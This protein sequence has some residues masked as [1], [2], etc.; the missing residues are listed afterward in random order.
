MTGVQS[1]KII[2]YIPAVI[3]ILMIVVC[4]CLLQTTDVEELLEFT[5]AEPLMALGVLWLMYALKSLS[6]VFPLT[7]L[8]IAAG[9][10]FPYPAAVA[11]N[12]AGLVVCFTLPYYIG[13]ISGSDAVKLIV[14]KYPKAQKFIDYGHTNN[15]L[16]VYISRAITVVPCDL[17]SMLHGALG[18]P[19]LTYIL[20]SLLGMMPEMLVITYIGG[21]LRDLTWRSVL[22]MLGLI[23]ATCTFSVLLNKRLSKLGI[24]TEEAEED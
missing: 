12:A 24:E 15:F 7:V 16:T 19:L 18:M 11:V 21:Q 3:C 13:K 2:K 5:S 22:V 17:V 8:F 20:G 6:I 9:N 10:I 1:K 4:V 23:A 14:E